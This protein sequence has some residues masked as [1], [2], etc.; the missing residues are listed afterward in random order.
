MHIRGDVGVIYVIDR[1][2]YDQCPKNSFQRNN[3]L[4]YGRYLLY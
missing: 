1:E 2:D 4:Y 3:H